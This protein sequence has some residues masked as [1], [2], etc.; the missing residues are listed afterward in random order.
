MSEN[1]TAEVVRLEAAQVALR[2]HF[3]GWQCRLRQLAVREGEGRP[4]AGMRP[5]IHRRGGDEALAEVT[6]LI[7]QRD[8]FVI[9]TEFQHLC[10][11]TQDPRERFKNALKLLSA[12][13]YQYPEDFSDRLTALY[14]PGSDTAESLKQAGHCDLRFEQ[15]NQRYRLP[16]EIFELPEQDPAYQATFWHNRL[17]NPNIP[18]GAR[19]LTFQPDWAEAEADPAP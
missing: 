9:T 4:S 19:V 3:L 7:V 14:A 10:R 1:S 16:C 2:R 8:P 12:S 17:F 15:F 18:G 5:G 11:K 6:V 13:Y